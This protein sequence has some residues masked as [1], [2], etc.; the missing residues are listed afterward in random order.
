MEGGHPAKER[1]EGWLCRFETASA[2]RKRG[3]IHVLTAA[4]SDVL[5]THWG[6]P[7]GCRWQR[8]LDCQTPL[9]AEVEGA[10]RGQP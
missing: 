5:P 7:L 1:L 2:L 8:R 10:L 3:L 6:L 9:D 4:G